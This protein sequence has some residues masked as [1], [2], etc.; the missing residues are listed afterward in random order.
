[1]LGPRFLQTSHVSTAQ[2]SELVKLR[3]LQVAACENRS[4]FHD[5]ICSAWPSPASWLAYF[6]TRIGKPP[7]DSFHGSTTWLQP[8]PALAHSLFFGGRLYWH[9]ACCASCFLRCLIA[10]CFCFSRVLLLSELHYRTAPGVHRSL[11]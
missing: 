2:E 8:R 6:P 4:I 1:M 5:L 3:L 11:R 9:K 10:V 7:L